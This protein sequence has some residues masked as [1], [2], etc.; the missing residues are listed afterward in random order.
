MYYKAAAN[1]AR[2]SGATLVA[3]FC[4]FFFQKEKVTEVMLM[5]KAAGASPR[6]TSGEKRKS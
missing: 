4:N 6:P 1:E 2:S 5:P 3:S